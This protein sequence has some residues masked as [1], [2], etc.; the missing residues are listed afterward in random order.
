MYAKIR[1]TPT[2]SK[3]H[4][5]RKV[6][7]KFKKT[8]HVVTKRNVATMKKKTNISTFAT[9]AIPTSFT[10]Q[11]TFTIPFMTTQA[12]FTTSHKS[13][14]HPSMFKKQTCM[15]STKPTNNNND[16]GITPTEHIRAEEIDFNT[17]D[18]DDI[19]IEDPNDGQERLPFTVR[20]ALL[21]KDTLIESIRDDENV[22]ASLKHLGTAHINAMLKDTQI[23]NLLGSGTLSVIQHLARE[24]EIKLPDIG[25]GTLADTKL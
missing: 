16:E 11:T 19:A 17:D 18:V 21:I 3:K 8:T 24:G 9:T 15:F 14:F 20:D 25:T 10:P 7:K 23:Q 13:P 12:T 6:A 4:T 1:K 5:K 22:K 2:A